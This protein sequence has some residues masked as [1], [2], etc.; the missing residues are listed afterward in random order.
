MKKR[1]IFFTAEDARHG[2]KLAG[3]EQ[4]VCTSDNLES[5]LDRFI[6]QDEYGLFVIDERI[7]SESIDKKL[8]E[9]EKGLDLVFV[10]LPPPLKMEAKQEDYAVRL[11]RK[12]IGYHIQ[13][14]V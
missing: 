11:L 8:R 12:A 13:L 9:L 4:H 6:H 7:V 5:V 1:I 2:F 14:N 10:I 3:F